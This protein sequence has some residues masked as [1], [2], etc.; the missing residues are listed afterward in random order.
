MNPQVGTAPVQNP[1]LQFLERQKSQGAPQAP[2]QAQPGPQA[3]MKQATNP[4]GAAPAAPGG[5]A[6]SGL[7]GAAQPAI[8]NQDSSMPGA[9]PGITK[10]LLQAATA[11]HATI[12]ELTDPDEIRTIRTI[13][14]L[15]QNLIVRDQQ[16]QNGNTGQNQ[17]SPE[18]GA[19]GPP[20]PPMGPA[21]GAP[22]GGPQQGGAPSLGGP[23]AGGPP[24]GFGGGGAPGG[25]RPF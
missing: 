5:G 6:P 18:A 15:L 4:V 11:L 10:G 8:Q 9:N 2:G 22:V 23:G 16:K 24:P 19:G 7:P 1:F 3:A 12:A 20:P 13:L 21:G 17:P 14:L 25:G